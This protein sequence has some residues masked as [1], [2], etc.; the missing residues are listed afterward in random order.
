MEI[1]VKISPESFFGWQYRGFV[2]VSLVKEDKN[3]LIEARLSQAEISNIQQT[4]ANIIYY[5]RFFRRPG[6][7]RGDGL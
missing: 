1:V 6:P 4:D 2:S 3:A 7:D 5:N